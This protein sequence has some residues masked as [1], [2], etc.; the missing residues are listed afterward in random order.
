MKNY[1]LC[2]ELYGF[3]SV[4]EETGYE[5]LIGANLQPGMFMPFVGADLERVRLLK[6]HAEAIAKS[7]KI[8]VRLYKFSNRDLLEE[9]N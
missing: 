7:Q 9:I 3:F 1:K 8:K 6:P 4:D 5:G 2:T